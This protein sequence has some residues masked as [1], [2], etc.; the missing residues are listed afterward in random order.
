[1]V[2]YLFLIIVFVFIYYIAEKSG[3]LFFVFIAM[4]PPILIEGL[5][6]EF[7]GRDMN[8]YGS[9]WFYNMNTKVSIREMIKECSTPEYGYHMLIYFCKCISKDIHL[10]MSVCALIKTLMVYLTAWRMRYYLNSIVFILAYYLFF[11]VIGFSLMRQSIA[12]AICALS[13]TYLLNNNLIKYLLLVLIAYFFHNSAIFMLLLLPFIYIGNFRFRYLV[14]IISALIIYT[15]IS[16]LFS[17]LTGSYLFKEG[18]VERYM[19]SGVKTQKT[20]I[21]ISIAFFVYGLYLMIM[22]NKSKL[23]YIFVTSSVFSLVFVL[24]ANYIE[25]AFRVAFYLVIISMIVALCFIQRDYQYKFQLQVTYVFLFF[26]HFYVAGTH[27]FSD[28]L[29][30]SSKI[31]GIIL[32]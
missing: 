18:I 9:A 30:Y 19:N 32:R 10:Y 22:K 8:V 26:L 4:I 1:M 23:L 2:F 5:R 29:N 31:L 27:G 13:I 14:M 16:S 7:I 20:M 21:I 11:Y 17:L 6:D 12:L 24:L 15:S 3:K 25:V 28:A